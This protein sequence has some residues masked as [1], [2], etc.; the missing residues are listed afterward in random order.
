MVLETLLQDDKKKLPKVQNLK[1]QC[2]MKLG[3]LQKAVD[4][5]EVCLILDSDFNVAQNNMGNI[6]MQL[7]DYAKS[8]IYYK[9]SKACSLFVTS[10]L[11]TE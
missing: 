6:Y 1:G 10:I 7:K 2:Q 3:D 11:E 8:K 5:F 9:K 4:H